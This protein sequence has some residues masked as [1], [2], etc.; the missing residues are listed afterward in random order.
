MDLKIRSQIK[1]FIAVVAFMASPCT[2]E[3]GNAT[4]NR[5]PTDNLWHNAA[6]WT[7]ATVPNGDLDTATFG[8]SSASAIRISKYAPGPYNGIITTLD[9]LL[10][11]QGANSFTIRVVPVGAYGVY[12]V[13]DGEGIVNSSGVVQ[14]LVIAAS[15]NF[16]QSASLGFNN[17]ASASENIVITNQGGASADGSSTYG[18]YTVFQD[19]S[20]AA[21]ATL[22]NEG[23]TASGSIYGGFTNLEDYCSAES[24][25][26]INNPGTVSGAAAGHTLIQIYAPGSIGNSTFINN[27]ATVAGAEGGWTEIDGAIS[28]GATFLANGASIAD[29]QGGQVYTYGGDGYSFFVANGG[30]GSDAQ[31]GLI[32]VVYVPASDQTVVTAN[33]GANG[34]LGGTILIEDSADISLPQFQVFG[35]G[36]LDLTNVTDPT[37]PI[38]SLAGDGIV[39]LAGHELSVGNNNLSTTF[40]G[41][42]Q[43]SGGLIKAGTAALTLTGANTYTGTTTVTAGTL[44]VNNSTGSG[45]GNGSVRV[46]AGTL[47]GKGTIAGLVTIGTGSG[48]GAVLA[49][50]A[51][52]GQLAVLTLQRS[53]TFKAD[54][55]YSYKLNT[56]NA[57][58]D[59]VIARGVT[60]QS[61]AQFSFQSLANRRLP[62]GTIFTVISNTSANPISRTFANLPD[63]STFTAGRNNYQASYE[64][65]DGN[66][67]TLTVVP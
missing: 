54:G 51:G 3:A 32:D 43:E 61:G 9:E 67:L 48:T 13:F 12:L 31:G 11:E 17:S 30:D 66:D 25:T 15:G 56:N 28:N 20:T 29:A 50:S 65:G 18:A 33:G 36:V 7:P 6:N 53:L 14:N 16:R 57:R 49:P 22:V 8:A 4:W 58:A 26:F 37:M 21:M 35:D 24:A 63:G 62:S 46:Q 52:V 10:F 42:I 60:I 40:S 44:R 34:G 27:A 23:S 59:Q 38:G 19:S 1:R 5:N 41:V 2:L 55:S 64:A 45:T 47:G 39:L